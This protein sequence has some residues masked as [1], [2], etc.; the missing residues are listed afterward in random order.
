LSKADRRNPYT[1][2]SG[3]GSSGSRFFYK[4]TKRGRFIVFDREPKNPM[5]PGAPKIV[6][7]KA[8]ERE[9]KGQIQ[10]LEEKS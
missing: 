7:N 5:I 10:E 1:R 3:H 4:K 2:P 8:N 6:G 9:A